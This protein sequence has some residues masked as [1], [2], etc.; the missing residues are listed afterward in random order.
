LVVN[1]ST[2]TQTQRKL[3]KVTT[4]GRI[5]LPELAPYTGKY[6]TYTI[7]KNNDEVEIRI[8]FIQVSNNE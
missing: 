3:R 5:A 2:Q 7:K 1:V 8:H 6:F 4:G